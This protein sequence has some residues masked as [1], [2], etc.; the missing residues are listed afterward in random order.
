MTGFVV[1]ATLVRC[2]FYTLDGLLGHFGGTGCYECDQDSLT[3]RP[4]MSFPGLE[5][6]TFLLRALPLKVY[7]GTTYP[8][9]YRYSVH[10]NFISPF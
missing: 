3:Y 4:V 5:P 10:Y 9:R 8:L 1:P 2:C 6:G 7:Q